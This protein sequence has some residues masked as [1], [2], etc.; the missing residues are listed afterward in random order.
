MRFLRMPSVTAFLVIRAIFSWVPYCLLLPFASGLTRVISLSLSRERAVTRAQMESV[1]RFIAAHPERYSAP[2]FKSFLQKLAHPGSLADG[3]FA[4]VGESIAEVLTIDAVLRQ[5][6]T[7][8]RALEPIPGK[9]TCTST[10]QEIVDEILR[11]SKGA[12]AL[13]AHIGCFELLAAYHVQQG[14][15]LLVVGRVPNDPSLFDLMTKI[16]QGYGVENLWRDEAESSKRLVQALR[17][18]KIVAALIDQDVA[19]ENT[20]S[21]FFGLEAAVP[22]ALIK[23]A[24]RREFPLVTSFIVRKSRY[25]HHVLTERIDYDASDPDVI[26]K[27]LK[28]YHQRLEAIIAEYPEQWIWWHRRWRR[29]PEVNYDT[30][31]E[32]LRGTKAYVEW[33]SGENL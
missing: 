4:H 21:T 20:Y 25:H 2:A 24:I 14:S 8:P 3:M 31:P 10:G 5:F 13:S 30:N 27:I 18:G 33:M 16:R 19:L 28:V 17:D 23:L 22:N 12:V 7:Q 11:D 9:F 32:Q 15:R 6:R 26:D 29:R 1:R